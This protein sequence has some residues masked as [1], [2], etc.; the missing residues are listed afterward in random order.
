SSLP[1]EFMAPQRHILYFPGHNLHFSRQPV[2]HLHLNIGAGISTL[3]RTPLQKPVFHIHHIE[4]TSQQCHQ[5]IFHTNRISVNLRS[6]LVLICL[7]LFSLLCVFFY[8]PRGFLNG[9][10]P[11]N[12]SPRPFGENVGKS[13]F[14]SRSRAHSQRFIPPPRPR[15]LYPRSLLRA[16]PRRLCRLV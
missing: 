2:Q 6:Q 1:I 14:Q 16:P 3:P 4:T 9:T 8:A 12:P 11:H 5:P 7:R 13:S 15:R 10:Q